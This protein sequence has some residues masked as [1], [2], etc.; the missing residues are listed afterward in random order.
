VSVYE[1]SFG[2]VC[3]V[4]AGVFIKKGAKVVAFFLG[5][6]FVLLQYLGSSS[7]V[8]V[9]WGRMATRFENLFYRVD[10]TTGAKRAPSVYSL[11]SWMVDFLTANFQQR[12][13]FLAGL[14]LGLRIG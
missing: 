7:V 12:A 2:T 5:G 10:R 8:R 3:G 1:L 9:D 6:V 11:W 13:S 4:C 14:A